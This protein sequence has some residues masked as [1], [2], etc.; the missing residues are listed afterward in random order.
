[1]YDYFNID[2]HRMNI[3]LVIRL[4]LVEHDEHIL[5]TLPFFF[6]FDLLFTKRKIA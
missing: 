1:V 5:C 2:L 4:V 6:W 3:Y